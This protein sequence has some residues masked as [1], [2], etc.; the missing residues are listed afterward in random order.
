MSTGIRARQAA[1]LV[2]S[3]P[4]CCRLFEKLLGQRQTD[5]KMGP[6]LGT[7]SPGRRVSIASVVFTPARGVIHPSFPL[8]GRWERSA[9]SDEQ[10]PSPSLDSLRVSS[11][12]TRPRQP[13]MHE[14]SQGRIPAGGNLSCYFSDNY[15]PAGYNP[16]APNLA[17]RTFLELPN[18]LTRE[19][20]LR[21]T[22]SFVTQFQ[23]PGPNFAGVS[24]LWV[25]WCD[26]AETCLMPRPSRLTSHHGSAIRRALLAAALSAAASVS[27][28]AD[29]TSRLRSA[30]T[31]GCYCC[32]SES[33]T[34][35]GCVKMCELP[36]YVS[37]WWATTC[38][39]P[40]IRR[41]VDNS[42]AGP[43]LHHPDR[44]EHARL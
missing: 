41:P 35:G 3:P 39:K 34:R 4:W 14:P 30:L 33:K 7:G 25:F 16:L 8:R 20:T 10:A 28:L 37:R 40:H 15:A 2:Q 27:L 38:A 43:H 6:P 42:N 11:F 19:V 24:A 29:S 23:D 13:H 12:E 44:A 1:I 32:C 22:L 18:K 9:K 17:F 26:R 5:K 21:L 31:G 36:K